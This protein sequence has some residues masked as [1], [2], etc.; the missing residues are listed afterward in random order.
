MN[1]G[2]FIKETAVLCLG[3]FKYLSFFELFN[4]SFCQNISYLHKTQTFDFKIKASEGFLVE[5]LDEFKK[6]DD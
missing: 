3:L 2:N 5:S 1:S 4:E 6:W